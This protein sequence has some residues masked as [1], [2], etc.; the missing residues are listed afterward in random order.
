MSDERRI[1]TFLRESGTVTQ[2]TRR[3]PKL[4]SLPAD[5]ARVHFPKPIRAF[6]QD[7]LLAWS[8][9]EICG[10]AAQPALQAATT[11]GGAR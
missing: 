1:D 10:V 8:A 5:R 3:S 6:G 4:H 9:A 2:V 7:E 11:G